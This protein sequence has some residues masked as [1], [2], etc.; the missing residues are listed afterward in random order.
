MIVSNLLSIIEVKLLLGIFSYDGSNIIQT[1][2]LI[3]L[4]IISCIFIEKSLNVNNEYLYIISFGLVL[5]TINGLAIYLF[6]RNEIN[7]LL[8]EWRV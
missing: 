5:Y 3:G 6:R 1:I 4:N 2:G 8:D 7:N